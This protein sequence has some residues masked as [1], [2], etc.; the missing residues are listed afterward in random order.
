MLEFFNHKHIRRF[1]FISQATSLRGFSSPA[2]AEL[3][4]NFGGVLF[5]N[6]KAARALAREC[7]R[8]LKRDRWTRF[9]DQDTVSEALLDSLGIHAQVPY[10]IESKPNGSS[11]QSIE[12]SPLLMSGAVGKYR[13]EEGADSK[14]S[15]SSLG[16]Y[17]LLPAVMAMRECQI[18][19][20]SELVLF[21][22]CG[23]GYCARGQVID[24]PCPD[25]PEFVLRS[26]NLSYAPLTATVSAAPG[27]SRT[28]HPVPLAG[29]DPLLTTTVRTFL[30]PLRASRFCDLYN[31][32]I[33]NRRE[34]L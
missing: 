33:F 13:V 23:I 17:L 10:M 34:R 27:H 9:P 25:I 29:D 19:C 20:Q 22:H 32:H 28:P 7:R 24:S 11:I 4:V 26:T 15:R 18:A 16:N 3:R 1:D 30:D 12:G 21:Q 8:V 31:E 5:R 2:N 6:T 14:Q